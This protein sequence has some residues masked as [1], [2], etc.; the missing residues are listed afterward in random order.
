MS[1]PI[2]SYRNGNYIVKL[3]SDGTKIKTTNADHFDADFPD[4]MDIKITNKCDMNCPMCHE[5]STSDGEHADLLQPFFDTI[6]AGT[7]IALGGGNPLSHPLLIPFLE[8][9]KMR[10][11]ISNL[12]VNEVH[13]LDHID[14]LKKLMDSK[15]IHGLGISLNRYDPRTIQ[16]MKE[17]RNTVAHII[18]GIVTK[19]Q[20]DILKDNNIKV[21]ILGYKRFGRGES[22]YSEEIENKISMIKKNLK[23]LI[24][25]IEV[26]S[27]DNLASA[28][29]DIKSL[30]G[31]EEFSKIYMGDDG[32]ATMYIDAVK[33]EYAISSTSKKRYPVTRNVDEMFKNIKN[34]L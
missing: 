27:F 3:Y 6:N 17:N 26:V 12:T 4:S 23:E 7:E 1:F 18:A 5:M 15:L 31:E 2:S 16:F 8:R 33:G 34:T 32:E 29:L 30:V 19:E 10:K 9:M 24:E 20:L 14:L 13:F 22:F 25:N 21:L 11:V 28:Q